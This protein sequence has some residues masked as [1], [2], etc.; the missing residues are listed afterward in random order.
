MERKKC[1]EILPHIIYIIY[2]SVPKIMIIC[3]T[4]PEICTAP[5]V[6]NFNF[7]FWVIFCPFTPLTARKI[8][9]LKRWKK[10]S[11]EISSFYTCAPKIMITW[12]TTPE[13]WCTMD[14]QRWIHEW[15]DRKSDIQRWV[16]HLKNM[17]KICW[18][19][20][21]FIRKK[22]QILYSLTF[23]MACERGMREGGKC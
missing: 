5:D 23:Y 1:L 12:C 11:Q 8:K 14:E 15:T 2:I 10:K 18:L 22:I 21:Y 17:I 6:C 7:S 19:W 3:Y 4:V 16:S 13:V 9:V 20:T